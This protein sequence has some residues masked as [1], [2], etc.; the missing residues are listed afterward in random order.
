MTTVLLDGIAYGM[1]LFL[2]A[3]GLSVTMG[4]MNLVNLAHG[5]FAML[6]GY[7]TVVSIERFGI[8]YFLCLPLAFLVAAI[9][10]LVLERLLYRRIYER[11]HLDQVTFTIGLVFMAIASA[12]WLMGAQQRLVELPEL[13]RMRIPILDTS[14][15]LY[16]LLVIG[17]C[18]VLALALQL[19][20]VRTRLGMQLRAAVD[21][22]RV[23]RGLGIPVPRI[24]AA[25]FAFGCGLA[26]LAGALGI[27][28]LGLDPSFPLRWIV[29]FL[30]VVAVGGTGTVSGPFFASLLLGIADVAIRYWL[31]ELGAF[32]IYAVMVVVLVLR[33][34]GLFARAG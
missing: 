31:P 30:L 23:A 18:A 10:G 16:R 33:P 26:G 24:F 19:L 5:A 21:D 29:Y 20:L 34:H 28:V 2:M 27:E 25:V 9:F 14:L 6:G 13:L 22:R 4:L 3:V 7:V 15:S 1:I 12:D 17:V 8:S 11:D 32:A